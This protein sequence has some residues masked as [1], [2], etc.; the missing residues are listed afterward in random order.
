[1]Q[2]NEPVPIIFVTG[3]LGSGKSTFTRICAKNGFETL[4]ADEIVDDLYAN[5]REM[6]LRL[7]KLLGADIVDEDG[8]VSK[9]KIAERVFSDST[10]LKEVESIIHPLVREVLNQHAK[11]ADF[12]FYEIPVVSEQTDLS[13]A[14]YV[15]V[16]T[17][18]EA[19]RINRAVSRGMKLEDAEKRIAAQQNNSFSH[20]RIIE[21]PNNG[22][23]ESFEE[24]VNRFLKDISND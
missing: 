1:M 21:I 6:V 16:I 5:N 19:T 2:H 12:L 17:A 8:V 11:N 23:V 3:G 22:S 10:L 13:N 7:K 4:S 9:S 14:D 24:L 18:D 15:V 20:P